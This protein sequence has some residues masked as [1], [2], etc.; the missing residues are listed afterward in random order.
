MHLEARPFSRRRFLR[1]VG[2]GLATAVVPCA[3]GDL[4]TT[5]LRIERRTLELPKWD[6]SGFQ[7]AIMSDLH[8][9]SETSLRFAT[10]V[11]HHA[12]EAKPNAILLPGDL[13]DNSLAFRPDLLVQMLKVFESAP[14][15]VIASRGNHDF[16]KVASTVFEDAF[17]G[18]KARLLINEMTEVDGVAIAGLDSATVGIHRPDILKASNL[19]TSV[20]CLLHEPD[21]V[22]DLPSSVSLQVSGHSHGGQVCLPFG[23]PVS[24]PVGARKYVAG[25]YED[26]RVPLYVSRGVGTVGLRFR[27]FCPPE[28]SLLTLVGKS[29]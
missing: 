10:R 25:Y 16:P 3:Y 19:P 27:T 20:I 13:L 17:N 24:T 28:L 15:P 4:A 7:I 11:A 1:A 14:C 12:M 22:S 2:A 9:H 18:L 6:A 8:L 21:F 23:I 29:S 5:D 26:A